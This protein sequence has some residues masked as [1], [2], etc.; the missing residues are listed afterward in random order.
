VVCSGPHS[1]RNYSQLTTLPLAKY[2]AAGCLYGN[3]VPLIN[4]DQFFSWL[5]ESE[6]AYSN[7]YILA[8]AEETQRASVKI[9]WTTYL[10]N[11]ND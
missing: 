10:K 3:T 8:L 7:L 4:K 9:S 6:L 1:G 5:W 11:N 2:S